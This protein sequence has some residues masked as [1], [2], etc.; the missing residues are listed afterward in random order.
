MSLT[1]QDLKKIQ[2]VVNEAVNKTIDKR[3]LAT[4]EDVEHAIDKRDLAS[5]QDV[6]NS[7][8]RLSKE[9]RQVGVGVTKTQSILLQH[10]D[11]KQPWK[12]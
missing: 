4:K 1:N 11:S 5:R 7:E 2:T 6:L 9:V 8:E 10:I 12:H 3:G